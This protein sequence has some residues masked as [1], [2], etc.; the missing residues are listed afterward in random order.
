MYAADAMRP[1]IVLAVL[2]PLAACG[3]AGPSGGVRYAVVERVTVEQL[4]LDRRWDGAVWARPGAP[5]VYVDVKAQ[6]RRG[7]VTNEVRPVWRSGVHED[8]GRGDLPLVLQ[9]DSAARVALR[10]TVWLNVADRDNVGDDRLFTTG[11]FTF[12]DHAG[13]AVRGDTAAL[14]FG[15]GLSRV[16]VTVRWE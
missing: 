8:L 3:R 11:D 9:A 14:T 5:D 2:L 16:R 15:D 13:G 1:R 12:A 10:D 4:D 7:Y 6:G